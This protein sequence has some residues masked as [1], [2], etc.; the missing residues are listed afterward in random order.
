M[1]GFLFVVCQAGAE[2]ALKNE[3][4]RKHPTFRFAFSR[5]G[6]VTFRVPEE[7]SHDRK[8][9]LNCVFGRTWG[10]SLGKVTG[11]DVD[12]LVRE[13][14]T[15]LSQRYPSDVLRKFRHLHVW[16]RDSA[17]PGDNDFEP[18]I[19]PL[20]D[21]IGEALLRLRP[22]LDP[23]WSLLLN[24]DAQ[25]EDR[26]LDCVLVEPGEWWFGWHRAKSL[27]SCWP[28][29]VPE[30]EIPED[31]VSRT[32]MKMAESLL[33]SDLPIKRGD[34]CVEIGSSPGGSCQALLR[35]GC[36]VTGID[37]ADMD[38]LLTSNP[39]FTH[40]KGRAKTLKRKV[41]SR[42]RWLMADAS[43][44]P[45]YT[46]DTVEAIVTHSDVKVR[47][48]ILTLKLTTWNLAEQI[49]LFNKR[50]REWGFQRVRARQLAFNRQ[51]ICLVASDFKRP[52]AA[53]KA[54]SEPVAES[55]AAN[56]QSTAPAR[57]PRA[58]PVAKSA[59]A[60]KKR[61]ESQPVKAAKAAETRSSKI[62]AGAH[63]A[64]AP[65]IPKGKNN[66]TG[67]RPRNG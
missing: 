2:A 16:Q 40:I 6:F 54:E 64:V 15:E 59:A 5:P 44:A 20:A 58:I 55:P 46:L 27:E 31:M 32:Y 33:W 19:S 22:Q 23:E 60:P 30:I 39:M 35:H 9:D 50:V 52:V 57:K 14:W 43:V 61:A 63:P 37:P 36:A 10:Y 26:V 56:E 65:G 12:T 41:F 17:I 25:P 4:A 21:E 3:V 38:P 24:E 48:L 53:P 28:G 13:V 67:K 8:F 66:K 51:E 47:G 1:S 62:D 34:A 49:P 29:G 7:L 42:F 45:R 11:T 18:G